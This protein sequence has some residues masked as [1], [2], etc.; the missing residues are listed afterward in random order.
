METEF[1]LD[2]WD[3]P[4]RGW[5]QQQVNS[6]LVKHWPSLELAAGDPVLIPLCGDSI[7]I[8]WLVASGFCVVGSELSQKGLASWFERHALEWTVEPAVSSSS[9][10][11]SDAGTTLK[12]MKPVTSA[13]QNKYVSLAASERGMQ[14]I[15]EQ[16]PQLAPTFFCGDFFS[17]SKELLSDVPYAVYDRA[18]LIALPPLMRE[19][20]VQ[21][22]SELLPTGSKILLITLIYDPEQ[23][24]GPPFSVS[25]SEVESLY[26]THFEIKK[27][28]D[29]QGP[30]IV[31]NL[32]DRGLQDAAESVFVLTRNS[33]NS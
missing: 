8:D 28:A 1:W 31:G 12:I 29:S 24:N 25:N 17:L 27:I 22:L 6:R 26:S 20:Y 30:D 5:S 23:M 33:V 19:R 9:G 3:A 15:D 21:K 4:K 16:T 7:D 2:K 13:N 32:A 18:A 11:G 10:L 14:T